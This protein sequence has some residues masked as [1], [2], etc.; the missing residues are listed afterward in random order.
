[1]FKEVILNYLERMHNEFF[2]TK[3]REGV[4]FPPSLDHLDDSL[5]LFLHNL[6][7]DWCAARRATLDLKFHLRNP[8][9]SIQTRG[10]H[11]HDRHQL[12]ENIE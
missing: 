5:I 11:G 9:C 12:H 4:G 3:K 6:T 2:Y 1:M 8:P 10:K 7:L